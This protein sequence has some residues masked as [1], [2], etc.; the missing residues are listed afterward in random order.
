MP[1]GNELKKLER[2]QQVKKMEDVV[3]MVVGSN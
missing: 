3:F 2:T 1:T